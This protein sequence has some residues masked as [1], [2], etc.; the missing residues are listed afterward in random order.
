MYSNVID[1]IYGY[2][3]GTYYVSGYLL[4]N[5]RK[6]EA[7]KI[8]H[9]EVNFFDPVYYRVNSKLAKP[10]LSKDTHVSKSEDTPNTHTLSHITPS[11]LTSNKKKKTTTSCDDDD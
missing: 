2:G 6:V 10:N 9:S 4:K 1:M 5:V 11:H 3:M 7:K 8:Y